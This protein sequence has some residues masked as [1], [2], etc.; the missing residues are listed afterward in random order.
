MTGAWSN[1]FQYAVGSCVRGIKVSWTL[2]GTS[3][4]VDL[5]AGDS[6]PGK[7]FLRYP[8]IGD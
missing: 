6:F 3:S 1:V 7:V 2:A 4:P 8:F 5:L